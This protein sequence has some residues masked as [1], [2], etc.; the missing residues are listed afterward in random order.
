MAESRKLLI[1]I[2]SDAK[3]VV[4]GFGAAEG[5][6]ESFSKKVGVKAIEVGGAIS[7]MAAGL[8]HLSG[9][10]EQSRKQFEASLTAIGYTFEGIKDQV[11][12]VE[13]T[14]EGFG[15]S[16]SDT[17]AAL[18]SL[19][20]ATHDPITALGEMQLVADIAAK[21]H[22]SL[23]D[24]AMIVGK[25]YNGATKSLK[26]FGIHMDKGPH[27]AAEM[28]AA[29]DKVALSL[30]GQASASVDTF[31]GKIDVLKTKIED[32]VGVHA[33]SVIPALTVLGPALVGIGTIMTAEVTP[34]II[35][36]VTAA[37]PFILAAAAIAAI[38][39]VIYKNWDT[40]AAF[41]SDLWN[42]VS[43]AFNNKWIAIAALVIAPMIAV[44][45][46]IAKN[47]QNLVD[48]FTGVWDF[49]SGIFENKWG[50][51]AMLVIAPII[52]IPVLI[53]KNWDTLVDFFHGVWKGIETVFATGAGIVFDVWDGVWKAISTVV[54]GYID[55]IKIVIGGLWTGIKYIINPIIT[56]INAVITVYDKF[57]KTFNDSPLPGPT[58]PIFGKIESLAKG[59]IVNRPTLA[60]IG[61]AG[62]EAVVPLN[63]RN[64]AG[65]GNTINIYVNDG[66][67]NKIIAAIRRYTQQNGPGWMVA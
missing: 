31:G 39:I 26:E 10:I 50:R 51:I 46:L 5:A 22:I 34:S 38:A 49:I 44:P 16:L 13:K 17:D 27:S 40:I 41:F 48:F 28:Q 15:H 25:A 7:G 19:T 64:G 29:L 58:F 43:D 45:I 42:K 9:P 6:T 60:L 52:G 56:A 67:P 53:A 12:P 33:K 57:A 21:K 2:L 61:E 23:T 55:G 18:T 30:K 65:L 66:D 11:T 14:M 63:G 36:A 47:W 59:G 8:E 4:K 62:P 20:V 3:D 54:G 24:A 35:A 1:E 32:W 37:A